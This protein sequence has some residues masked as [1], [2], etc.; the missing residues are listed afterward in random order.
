MN[1]FGLDLLIG[2]EYWPTTTNW[3]NR[4]FKSTNAIVFDTHEAYI[5]GDCDFNLVQRT[6]KGTKNFVTPTVLNRL[7]NPQ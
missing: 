7:L 3:Q 1:L 6:P 2:V 5:W 4:L